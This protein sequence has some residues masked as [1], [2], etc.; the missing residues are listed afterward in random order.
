MLEEWIDGILD[1]IDLQ[2]EQPMYA[3]FQKHSYLHPSVD[4]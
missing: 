4:K 2:M 3:D 1:K